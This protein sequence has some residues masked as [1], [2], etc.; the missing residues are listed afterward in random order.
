MVEKELRISFH[1]H[2]NGELAI[3]GV[4]MKFTLTERSVYYGTET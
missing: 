2:P 4:V 1:E 3:V